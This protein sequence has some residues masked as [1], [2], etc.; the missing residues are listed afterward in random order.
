MKIDENY[1]GPVRIIGKVGNT[2]PYFVQVLDLASGEQLDGVFRAVVTL[3][4]NDGRNVA[5]LSYH[6][7]DETGAIVSNSEKQPPTRE[8]TFENPVI[9][10][11]ALVEGMEK[12]LG[13]RD[14]L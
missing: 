14:N 2:Q 7:T 5:T 11:S 3:D 13:K 6:E 8:A 10:V 12:A 9:D 4:A 1:H